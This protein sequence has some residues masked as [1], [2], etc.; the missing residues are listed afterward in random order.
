MIRKKDTLQQKPELIHVL[1]VGFD[2]ENDVTKVDQQAN[3]LQKT[4][5]ELLSLPKPRDYLIPSMTL[6]F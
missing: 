1:K 5:N 6:N 2:I 4:A 3:L